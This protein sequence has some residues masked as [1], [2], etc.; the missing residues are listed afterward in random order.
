MDI[1]DIWATEEII[2]PTLCRLLGYEV[3]INPCSYT[4]VKYKK[5]YSIQDVNKAIQNDRAFWI[6]PVKRDYENGIRQHLRKNASHY[7]PVTEN[8][9]IKNNDSKMLTTISNLIDKI[10]HNEGWQS[11][12][13]GD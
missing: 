10:E 1:S 3:K 13:E 6:H 2:F 12:N 11:K 8:A 7:A 9:R 4:Y 5:D